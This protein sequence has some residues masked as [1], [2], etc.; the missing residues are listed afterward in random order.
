M[1]HKQFYRF[2]F[3]LFASLNLFVYLM[4]LGYDPMQYVG[5]SAL[6]FVGAY[7]FAK[8]VFRRFGWRKSTP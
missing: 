7:L 8:L 4:N 2:V 1:G 5:A 6:V 3:A